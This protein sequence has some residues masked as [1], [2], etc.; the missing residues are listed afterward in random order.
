MAFEPFALY[1]PVIILAD[2]EKQ[3]DAVVFFS[4]TDGPFACHLVGIVFNVGAVDKIDRRYDDLGAGLVI[5]RVVLRDDVIDRV[6]LQ[7]AR[8]VSNIKD[9]GRLRNVQGQCRNDRQVQYGKQADNPKDPQ[10][11]TDTIILDHVISGLCGL[12]RQSISFV[13]FYWK[14]EMGLTPVRRLRMFAGKDSSRA[15]NFSARSL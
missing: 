1:C 9:V 13:V 10:Q 11:R 4:G 14:S 8:I 2:Y 3:K 15:L 6:L 5:Q 7:N 12:D